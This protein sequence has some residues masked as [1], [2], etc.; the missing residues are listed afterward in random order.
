MTAPEMRALARSLRLATLA[1]HFRCGSGHIGC[2]LSCLELLIAS[3]V[4]TK[5]P[6]ESFILSKGHAA[7]ALYVCLHHLGHISDE[8]LATVYHQ[9]GT[10]LPAHPAALQFPD[11]PFALG[12]LG[13]GLP[14]ATGIAKADQLAGQ[15]L[16]TFVVLSDGETNTGTTWEAGHFAVAHH[17]ERLLVLVDRNGLQGFGRTREILGDTADPRKWEAVGFEVAQC[18]GHDL[19]ALLDCIHRLQGSRDGRPKMLVADTVKGAG[20]SYMADRMEWHYLPMNREQ[21]DQAV[22]EVHAESLF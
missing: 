17:L 19:P 12:S 4:L 18:P 20:V 3:L 11:I 6:Q 15:D 14:I 13:H 9:E 21:Y 1:L 5:T 10:R 22:K 2:S 16:T 8:E 7:L